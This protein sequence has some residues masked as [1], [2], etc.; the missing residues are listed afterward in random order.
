M[1]EPA[2]LW[3]TGIKKNLSSFQKEKGKKE[4]NNASVSN[5]SLRQV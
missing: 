3:R 5:P 2:E 1:S 4:S